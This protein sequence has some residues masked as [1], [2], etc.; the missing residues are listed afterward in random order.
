MSTIRDAFTRL[1]G[2]KNVRADEV[3]ERREVANE[4]ASGVAP[5]AW[6][7]EGLDQHRHKAAPSRLMICPYTCSSISME[8]F[9]E[10]QVVTPLRIGLEFIN[11]IIQWTLL[12][13]ISQ[14]NFC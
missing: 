12:I 11:V 5:D 3:T 2:L 6:G 1:L 4:A 8:I 9:I 13:F 14:E 7:P 10:H